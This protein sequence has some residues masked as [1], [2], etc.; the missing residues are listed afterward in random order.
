M[1]NKRRKSVTSSTRSS[2]AP[3]IQAVFLEMII[4]ELK[5]MNEFIVSTDKL[6]IQ[7]QILEE[8]KSINIALK[9]LKQSNV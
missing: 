6:N 8:L 1:T 5:Y 2:R 3:T 4:E 9:E 7:K